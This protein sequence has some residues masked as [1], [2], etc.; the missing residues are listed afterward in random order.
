MGP[1]TILGVHLDNRL[2]EAVEVQKLF[3]EYGRFIKTRLGLH[4][5]DGGDDPN[6]LILLEIQ[7][8]PDRIDA[9]SDAL[10][11]IGGVEAKRMTFEHPG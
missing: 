4:D 1:H 5:I 3:T 7:A 10:N 11:A 6:G 2:T 9:L 8:E